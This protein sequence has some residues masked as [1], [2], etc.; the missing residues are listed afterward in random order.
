VNPKVI[1]IIPAWNEEKAIGNTIRSILRQDYPLRVVVS[2]DNCTDRT[3]AVAS[4]FNSVFVRE[5]ID[6]KARKAG[7]LNQIIQQLPDTIKYVLVIDADTQA[8]P[9]VVSRAV[10]LFEEDPKLGAI[11][12]R[13]HLSPLARDASFSEKI[14]WH[15]QRLEYATADSR[16]VERLDNI[17]IL[18]GSCVVYRMSA[19]KQVAEYRG[20]GQFYD[21]SNLIEDYELTLSLKELKW[22]VTINTEM[23]SWTNVPLSLKIQWQQRVRW[24]R[25]HIDTLIQKGWN[26]V[27]RRDILG[28]VA[29]IFLLPQ[30]VFFIG[31][32][33]YLLVSRIDFTWNP[34][35]WL[36]L[37]L[38]WVDRMYRIKYVPNLTFTDVIIRAAFL[39]EEIYGLW[40]SMQRVWSYFL[41]LT[42]KPEEWHL[43]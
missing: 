24:A 41:V 11:C 16:R 31:L 5:T 9:D 10:K 28:H 39:P 27:T 26:K 4:Q 1:V 22:K 35:L 33:V 42:N 12:A 19:L 15:L 40:H 29:F 18:A 13:T 43:T 7:A 32:L 21:E 37:G 6:N 14:W 38:F 23:H 36:I 17:Q 20:N 2:A 8:A 30:Q 34:F 25:S 3:V